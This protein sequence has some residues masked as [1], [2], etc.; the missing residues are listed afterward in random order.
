MNT[1]FI[2]D[3]ETTIRKGLK[4]VIDWE[5]LGFELCGEAANGDDALAQILKLQPD[6]VLLDV[7]MPGL[8]GT[9]VFS[10]ARDAGYQGKC[11]ILSGYSDFKYAQAAIKSGVSFY[12]YQAG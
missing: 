2:A 7:R 12:N 10:R 6:L 9:D 1:F 3:D 5:E 4:Y 8:N 11:I